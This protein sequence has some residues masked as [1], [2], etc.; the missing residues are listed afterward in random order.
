[1]DSDKLAMIWGLKMLLIFIK[2]EYHFIRGQ[3]DL[4]QNKTGCFIA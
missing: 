2:K 1:M 3:V 4:F